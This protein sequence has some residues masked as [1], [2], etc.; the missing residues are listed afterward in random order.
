MSAKKLCLLTLVTIL[1][2][3]GGQKQTGMGDI[4][5]YTEYQGAPYTMLPVD[6][7]YRIR[8]GDELALQFVGDPELS[9]TVMVRPDGRITVYPIGDFLAAGKTTT[10]LTDVVAEGFSQILRD[11]RLTIGVRTYGQQYV[12]VLGEVETPGGVLY[13][14]RLTVLRAIAIA[15]GPKLSAAMNSVV[16]IEPDVDGKPVGRKVDVAKIL[17]EHTFSDDLEISSYAIVYVPKSTIGKVNDFV[18]QFFKNIDPVFMTMLHAYQIANPE[19][20]L[21]IPR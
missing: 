4:R 1:C 20:I 3:C 19:E 12:Y 10:E 6:Q 17:N 13:N 18:E 21:S 7:E 15:G 5:P 16:V 11:P 8:S 2:G 14:E 9:A